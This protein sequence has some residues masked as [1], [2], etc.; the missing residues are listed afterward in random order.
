MLSDLFKDTV[1]FSR[2]S[3]VFFDLSITPPFWMQFYPPP[4][5]FLLPLFVVGSH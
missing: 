1:L 4:S 2:M 5:P 3:D